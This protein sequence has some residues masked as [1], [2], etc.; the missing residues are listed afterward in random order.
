MCIISEIFD[1][2]FLGCENMGLWGF[3]EKKMNFQRCGILF[4]QNKKGLFGAFDKNLELVVPF[5]FKGVQNVYDINGEKYICLYKPHEWGV[6]EVSSKKYI[7]RGDRDIP[8]LPL[9]FIKKTGEKYGLVNILGE[10]KSPYFYESIE[11]FDN[12]PFYEDERTKFFKACK[13]GKFGIMDYDGKEVTEF[14]Y[15]K[16]QYLTDS[17]FAYGET[18]DGQAE[19]INLENQNVIYS[20]LFSD[21]VRIT[22]SIK[23]IYVLTADKWTIYDCSGN[24][25]MEFKNNNSIKDITRFIYFNEDY[26]ILYDCNEGFIMNFRLMDKNGI[27]SLEDKYNWIEP[28][29]GGKYLLCTLPVTDYIINEIVDVKGHILVPELGACFNSQTADIM[30]HKFPLEFL[31]PFSDGKIIVVDE[32]LE[33][34]EIDEKRSSEDKIY[35]ITGAGQVVKAEYNGE[36]YYYAISPDKLFT[37][38]DKFEILKEIEVELY[39]DSMCE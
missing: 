16:I 27:E 37:L 4:A 23:Y 32:N 1:K 6:I 18:D 8:Y 20:A 12:E 17:I 9:D 11:K 15:S 7:K 31:A 35:E 19:I 5:E 3:K 10:F 29:E 38:N 39:D 34:T 36:T 24:A 30:E 22:A 13:N 2:F 28:V 21:F 14:K 33:V 25:V 26:L